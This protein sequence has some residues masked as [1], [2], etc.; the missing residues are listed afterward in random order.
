VHY[1]RTQKGQAWTKWDNWTIWLF[2][3]FGIRK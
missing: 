2:D 1:H 3:E